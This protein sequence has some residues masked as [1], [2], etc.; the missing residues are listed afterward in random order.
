MGELR[1][2]ANEAITDGRETLVEKDQ[3]GDA[4]CD[5]EPYAGMRL[6]KVQ[7]SS[8]RDVSRWSELG[9]AESHRS[10]PPRM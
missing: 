1:E 2:G 3:Y 10:G 5:D 7:V 4:V 6:A 8:C 9:A